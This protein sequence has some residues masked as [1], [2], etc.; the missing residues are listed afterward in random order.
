MTQAT[1]GRGPKDILEAARQ[2]SRRQAIRRLFPNVS[3]VLVLVSLLN[4]VLFV[5]GAFYVGGDAWN[6]KV[7]GQNYYVWGYHHGKN[8]YTR[9]S[10][11]VFEYS[12]WHVYSV[13]VTWPLAIV[14]AIV[15]ERIERRPQG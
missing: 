12:R 1:K 15:S 8:G 9:V 2:H 5:G 6:G 4:F 13:M 3:N 14:A 11:T 10:K 7:E